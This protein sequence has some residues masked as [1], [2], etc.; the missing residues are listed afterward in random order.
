MSVP[1][2]GPLACLESCLD[3]RQKST[4]FKYSG[5]TFMD[6]AKI[7]LEGVLAYGCLDGPGPGRDTACRGSKQNQMICLQLGQCVISGL[8]CNQTH[9]PAEKPLFSM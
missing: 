2:V 7:I 4:G 6:L 3:A 5:A 1:V 9:L 8:D